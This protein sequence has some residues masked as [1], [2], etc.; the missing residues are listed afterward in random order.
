MQCLCLFFAHKIG[1][2]CSD[3]VKDVTKTINIKFSSAKPRVI[4][5][6]EVDSVVVEDTKPFPK[7]DFL[8]PRT[9][10]TDRIAL[11]LVEGPSER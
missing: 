4:A 11:R 8:M 3:I 2:A 7:Y 6:A 1:Q 5:C 10:E 9:D